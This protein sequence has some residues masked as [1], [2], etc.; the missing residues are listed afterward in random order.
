MWSCKTLLC[1]DLLWVQLDRPPVQQ[2]NN[3]NAGV[4]MLAQYADM[5]LTD[6]AE[7]TNMII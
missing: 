5:T 4:M 3:I 6:V 2:V 1:E 7:C